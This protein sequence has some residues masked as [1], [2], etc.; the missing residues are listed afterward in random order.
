MLEHV[1][2]RN[3]YERERRD[4]E[5]K[6]GKRIERLKI[7]RESNFYKIIRRNKREIKEDASCAP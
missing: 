1:K 3:Q 2:R 4:N 7:K 5:N 6:E